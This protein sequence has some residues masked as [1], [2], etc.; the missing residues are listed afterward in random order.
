MAYTVN[1]RVDPR[2]EEVVWLIPI[3][4]VDYVREVPWIAPSRARPPAKKNFRSPLDSKADQIVGYTTLSPDASSITPGCFQRRTFRLREYDRHYDPDGV[5]ASNFPCEAVSPMDVRTGEP[6]LSYESRFSN[7]R[8]NP[9]EEEVV[10][11]IPIDDVDYVREGSWR[12]PSRARPPAKDTLRSSH[13]VGYTTLSP[14]AKSRTPGR[15]ERRLFSLR[16]YD[17]HYE[18][19]GTYA[20]DCPYEA[21]SPMDVK[22]GEP[23]L[24]YY[25]RLDS[26]SKNRR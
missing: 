26:E 20:N 13:V 25:F 2:E 1:P 21:V 11:L 17:R 7:H 5:Y 23:S 9:R 4:D 12:A 22:P 14:D 3:D 16:A 10:W 15:F 19:G 18:P 24:S 8:V 6:S